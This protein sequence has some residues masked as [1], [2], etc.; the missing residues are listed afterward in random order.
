MNKKDNLLVIFSCL[1][2]ATYVFTSLYTIYD[3]DR[4]IGKLKTNL[5]YTEWKLNQTK[6]YLEEVE[7][8]YNDLIKVKESLEDSNKDLKQEKSRLYEQYQSSIEKVEKMEES[9]LFKNITYDRIDRFLWNDDT[10][11]NE[12]IENNYTC[13]DYSNDVLKNAYDEG[14]YGCVVE[15]Y[16]DNGYAHAIISFNTTDEGIIYVEPQSDKIMKNLEI[17]DDY[18]QKVGWNC[19][20][21]IKA[22]KG[23]FD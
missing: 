20:Y 8:D 5:F 13:M 12:Y 19:D 21:E 18:C 10:D 1:I 11:D 6:D 4:E 2:L 15:M 3:M 16:M 22:I 9:K 23:C 17:G 7:R 14:I